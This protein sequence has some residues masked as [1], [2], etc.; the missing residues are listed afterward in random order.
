MN[1]IAFLLHLCNHILLRTSATVK[2][3]ETYFLQQETTHE[4]DVFPEQTFQR[5]SR[6]CFYLGCPPRVLQ[7]I[8]S[9][10]VLWLNY[11]QPE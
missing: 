11:S 1:N 5:P 8:F 6:D 4:I 9:L 2:V 3:S 7:T 10:L